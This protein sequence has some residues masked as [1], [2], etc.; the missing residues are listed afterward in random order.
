LVGRTEEM[1]EKLYSLDGVP[2]EIRTQHLPKTSVGRYLWTDPFDYDDE[3][4]G[5]PED[6]SSIFLRNV[7]NRVQDI[8]AEYHRSAL[9]VHTVLKSKKMNA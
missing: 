6:G 1:E 5:H 4:L 2:V 3:D 8:S 7:G 9:L